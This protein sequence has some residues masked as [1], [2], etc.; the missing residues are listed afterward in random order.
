[1]AKDSPT[2]PPT[3]SCH[4]RKNAGLQQGRPPSHASQLAAMTR[5]SP[6]IQQA[7]PASDKR[8]FLGLLYQQCYQPASLLSLAHYE[9]SF[10]GLHQACSA[11]PITHNILTPIYIFVIVYVVVTANNDIPQTLLLQLG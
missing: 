9:E 3:P 8:P 4:A 11:A 7:C 10:H 2:S 5:A 1:M 6:G